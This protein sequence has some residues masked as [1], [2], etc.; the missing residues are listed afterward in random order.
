MRKWEKV[1]GT[2]I[3]VHKERVENVCLILLV[4]GIVQSGTAVALSF[5]IAAL[6][7]AWLS[8][9]TVRCAVDGGNIVQNKKYEDDKDALNDVMNNLLKHA[10]GTMGASLAFFIVSL[11]F[12]VFGFVNVPGTGFTI[13]VTPTFLND[14]LAMLSAAVLDFATLCL[15]VGYG[16]DECRG[17][18][19]YKRVGVGG[20]A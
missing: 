16:L 5:S 7:T 13:P 20:D 19:G 1:G 12:V 15:Y 10:R 2:Q 17:G 8:K 14:F 9:V 4:M 3:C 18:K 6:C 11:L